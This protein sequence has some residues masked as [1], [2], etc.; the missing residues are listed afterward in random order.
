M[1]FIWKFI[2]EG[3][4]VKIFENPS[5][6]TISSYNGTLEIW[7]S[8]ATAHGQQIDFLSNQA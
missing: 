7:S 2:S 3:I 4:Y 8:I 1:N 6:D 5:A